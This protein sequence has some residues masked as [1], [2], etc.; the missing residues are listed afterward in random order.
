MARA[1]RGDFRSSELTPNSLQTARFDVGNPHD[2][3]AVAFEAT[4]CIA[5]VGDPDPFSRHGVPGVQAVHRT[6]QLPDARGEAV[7]N[8]LDRPF[9][10]GVW[11]LT[12]HLPDNRL[13][14]GG[15]GRL[16]STD[17][18]RK[19]PADQF[20][21]ELVEQSGVTVGREDDLLAVCLELLEGVE[22]LFLDPLLAVEEVDIIHKEDIHIPE[23]LPKADQGLLAQGLR[24]E[25]GEVLGGQQQHLQPREVSPEQAI[26]PFEQMRLANS[27]PTVNVQR[28]DLVAGCIGNLPGR[29][30]R[31]VIG[32]TGDE[33]AQIGVATSTGE[34]RS[35]PT[36]GEFACHRSLHR[37]RSVVHIVAGLLTRVV[38]IDDERGV[39]VPGEPALGP[40]TCRAICPSS[41]SNC[42]CTQVSRYG[43][44]T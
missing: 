35:G 27:H 44:P 8:E 40:R 14:G 24:E 23:P 12:G 34:A 18:P 42:F 19:E 11:P 4:Q 7:G 1:R 17:D 13:A 41:G 30:H 10:H 36:G 38:G 5:G 6:N 3:N 9:G 28:V 29:Q 31:H 22:E 16:D 32:R 39:D 20:F 33:L 37:P 2:T 15:I 26:R 25:V 21:G 43:L